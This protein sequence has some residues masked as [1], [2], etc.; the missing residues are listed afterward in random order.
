LADQRDR[1]RHQDNGP[2]GLNPSRTVLLR[3]PGRVES[4]YRGAD[5]KPKTSNPDTVAA[6]KSYLKMSAEPA[7]P[8]LVVQPGDRLPAGST[9]ILTEDSR[10]LP[11]PARV[12]QSIPFGYHRLLDRH[13]QSRLLIVS[14]GQCSLPEEPHNWG[15]SVQLYSARS[16]RSWGM[17]DLGDLHTIEEWSGKRGASYVLINPIHA[18]TLVPPIQ[19]SP[20]FPTSRRCKNPLFLRIED[21]PGADKISEQLEPLARA[22]RELNSRSLIDR[23]DIARLKLE[24][25]HAIWEHHGVDPAFNE[26]RNQMGED[27]QQYATYCALADIHG[28]QWSRW[29]TELQDANSPAVHDFAASNADT[30]SF[31]AW[32][33]YLLE[34]QLQLATDHVRVMHDLAI[35]VD[36][37]GADTWADPSLY[38]MDYSVGAPP[39]IF[40]TQG[41]DWGFPPFNPYQL[42]NAEY[43][44]FI[45]TLRAAFASGGALRFDHT[46]GL[47]RLWWI[48]E[49]HGPF[50]GA[51]VRYPARDLLNILALESWRAKGWVVGEA[52]G[53]VEAGIRP[54]L[55]ERNV[56]AYY[57]AAD[58]AKMPLER[59]PKLAQTVV[60]THDDPTLLALWDG[61]D[62]VEQ[63]ALG[64]QPNVKDTQVR[65]RRLMF[66][67]GIRNDSGDVEVV[68]KVYDALARARSQL[69]AASLS[70]IALQRDRINMPATTDDVRANWRFPLPAPLE[71]VLESSVAT[72]VAGAM[73]AYA[74]RD[75]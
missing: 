26:F 21:V 72:H 64:R 5:K 28:P 14:P 34:L 29:P 71:S 25:L 75:D 16:S 74:K 69:V 12:D 11:V 35:G 51:Y 23:D 33:Q 66:L 65:R 56:M 54:E 20:Y 48:P 41:Q 27:V 38:A 7:N 31:H 58:G 61:S 13:G 63:I 32:L 4:A 47:F 59:Y 60:L 53:T 24:A 6:V 45:S 44:P 55:A 62:L 22:G 57:L 43:H 17:G 52:L 36:R 30:V 3:S 8:P 9:E 50:D 10:S 68:E 39:D 19:P 15:L 37:H 70:D 67:S 42:M 2:P 1:S 18:T 49:N 46:I 40:A 73:S